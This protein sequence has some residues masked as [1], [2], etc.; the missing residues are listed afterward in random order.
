MSNFCTLTP[1]RSTP[2]PYQ[3]LEINVHFKSLSFIVATRE[4][5]H[6]IEHGLVVESSMHGCSYFSNL[7]GGGKITRSESSKRRFAQTPT[8]ASSGQNGPFWCLKPRQI[9]VKSGRQTVSNPAKVVSAQES[10]KSSLG[11][12]VARL[13]CFP[14]SKIL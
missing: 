5:R 7:V 10:H 8:Y 9:G 11:W 12:I 6:A 1:S 4:H 3:L 13:Q 14:S 2:N